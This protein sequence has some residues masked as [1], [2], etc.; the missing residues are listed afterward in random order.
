MIVTGKSVIEW[1]CRPNRKYI[2]QKSV[3][4]CYQMVQQGTA[5]FGAKKKRGPDPQKNA[6]LMIPNSLMHRHESMGTMD[7][8]SGA[9]GQ[10]HHRS[11]LAL[12]LVNQG[13]RPTLM[14]AQRMIS[15][16]ISRAKAGGVFAKAWCR[17]NSL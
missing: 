13:V 17:V 9:A 8:S 10:D 2:H 7:L 14:M 16:M 4:R 1:G 6:G 15:Q 12:R 5:S 3:T 11:A